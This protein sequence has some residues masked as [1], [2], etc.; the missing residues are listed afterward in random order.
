[1]LAKKFNISKKDL[2]HK[3]KKYN[4][5]ILNI[6]KYY[7][8]SESL[9]YKLC[10]EYKILFPKI[11]LLGF[12]FNMFTVIEKLNPKGK[13]GKQAQYWLCKCECGNTRE[14]P[15]SIIT[16]RRIKSCGCI[17]QT[18]KYKEQHHCWNG[19]KGI[20]GKRWYIIKNGAKKRGHKFDLNIKDAWKLY[21]KQNRKCAISGVDIAFSN[22]ISSL[23]DTTASL[24][25][26]DSTLGYTLDNVQWVHKEVNLMKQGMCMKQFLVWIKIIEKYN[27]I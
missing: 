3:L 14:Y 1:M 20:H 27:E 4:F 9:I 23:S 19:Y 5:K 17:Q 7:K 15:T 13:S 16:G 2:H 8:C 26:I 22:T 18:Q 21:E 10:Q 24:D 11:D 6:A 12:K 25:R